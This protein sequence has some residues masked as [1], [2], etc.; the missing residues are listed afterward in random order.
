MIGYFMA[1]V[2][3]VMPAVIAGA[4]RGKESAAKM[5]VTHVRSIGLHASARLMTSC[6]KLV[7][8]AQY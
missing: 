6:R 3:S 7:V 4:G 1:L 2:H 5:H 8:T